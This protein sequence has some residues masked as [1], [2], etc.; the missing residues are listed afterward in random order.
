M[1][2][3][4]KETHRRLSELM[5]S[6]EIKILK[7]KNKKY[8]IISDLHLGDGSE[9]DDFHGNEN[10]LRKALKEYLNDGF[11]LILLGDIEE[12]WQFDFNTVLGRYDNSVYADI[13]KFGKNRVYRIFGNHDIEWRGYSDPIREKGSSTST[14]VEALKL[15][16][17]NGEVSILLL[18]GH[19]GSLESDRNSWS[20]RF[21]VRAFKSVEPIAKFL[22]LYG[23]GSA[24]KSQIPDN[25]ERTFYTWAKKNKKIVIC[26]H[27][28]RAIFAAKS[29]AEKLQ[30]DIYDLQL[31]IQSEKNLDK[32][33]DYL[34]QIE[35]I[36]QELAE[37]N[38]K[39][40]KIE[41]AEENGNAKPCYFNTGCGLYTDGITLIEILNDEISL[42]KWN[43]SGKKEIFDN[44]KISDFISRF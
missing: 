31:K 10:A 36:N 15:E 9:A 44:G 19:Q 16:D 7:T 4:I 32:I 43:N 37:E 35:K 24:T 28:H 18:H 29:Y 42:V 34:R 5:N 41:A 14:A 30:E 17:V 1:A 26:G 6:D 39:G 22:G 40:R 23:E 12:F 21:F 25:Y 8:A 13:R 38:R 2:L 11:T 27:S 3:D 33:R 20:S